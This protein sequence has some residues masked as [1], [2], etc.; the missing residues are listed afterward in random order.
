MGKV[1]AT[2]DPEKSA[3][4][5]TL[6]AIQQ[7]LRDSRLAR[8]REQKVHIH[9]RHRVSFDTVLLSITGAVLSGVIFA[10]CHG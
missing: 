7:E 6:M 3:L 4:L 5:E 10:A 1:E 9:L 8:E 2:V